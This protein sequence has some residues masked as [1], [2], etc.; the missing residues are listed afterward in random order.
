MGTNSE[1]TE[2]ASPCVGVCVI[3]RCVIVSLTVVPVPRRGN[4]SHR[5]NRAVPCSFSGIEELR[6]GKVRP[7]SRYQ[8]HK[9]TATICY[10]IL[11]D[12]LSPTVPLSVG[13]KPL[14]IPPKDVG[15]YRE[16]LHIRNDAYYTD[17]SHGLYVLVRN[18]LAI[19]AQVG[20]F[21][22][23]TYDRLRAHCS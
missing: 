11:Y 6:R 5:R 15:M 16:I 23:E 8:V 17:R 14:S 4:E 18:G 3:A 22:R 20:F 1:A 13:T 10:M 19:S 7:G 2:E 21:W 9:V 12:Q